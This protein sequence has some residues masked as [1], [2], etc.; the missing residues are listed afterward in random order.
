M[1][2]P[3]LFSIMTG[4]N[5]LLSSGVITIQGELKLINICQCLFLLHHLF[6]LL[7]CILVFG[8]RTALFS[9]TTELKNFGGDIVLSKTS[10]C[11][12]E[13]WE[14]E[15]SESSCSSSSSRLEFLVPQIALDFSRNNFTHQSQYKHLGSF[16]RNQCQETMLSPFLSFLS[17]PIYKE[18]VDN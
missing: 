1:S 9:Y 13:L 3:P 6:S 2:F 15:R 8:W 18:H 10:W 5:R 4:S 14:R 7:I 12:A 16:K 11:S 17:V